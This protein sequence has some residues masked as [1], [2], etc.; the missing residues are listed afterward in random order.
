VLQLYGFKYNK[1]AFFFFIKVYFKGLKMKAH[2]FLCL[3]ARSLSLSRSH[4]LSLFLFLKLN[5][6]SSFLFGG[7]RGQKGKQMGVERSFSL[8]FSF[9]LSTYLPHSHFLFSIPFPPLSFSSPSLFLL[10][11]LFSFLLSLS[12]SSPFLQ[13]FFLPLSVNL[14]LALSSF[15]LFNTLTLTSFLSFS[16]EKVDFF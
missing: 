15:F 11:S 4:T 9:S 3:K 6:T 13:S 5:L 8:T 10:C 7:R 16:Q 2:I 12:L 14:Y 1:L